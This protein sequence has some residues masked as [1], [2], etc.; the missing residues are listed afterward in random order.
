MFQLNK[1]NTKL[2]IALE[3]G[4]YLFDNQS[5]TGK[6]RLCSVLKEYGAYGEPVIG[7]TYADLRRGM[8]ISLALIPE[9]YK[10][11][12]LDR[13]DMYCGAGKE[14][15]KQCAGSSIILIDCKG[16][17]PVTNEYDW[18]YIEMKAH[19]IEVA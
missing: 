12:M 4:I 19:S 5:A 3:N 1:Y 9:K 11:V 10:V 2:T 16:E 13:Y 17:F 15:I 7:Y 18:C 8:D 14:L 6:S